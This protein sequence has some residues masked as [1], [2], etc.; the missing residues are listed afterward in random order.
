[1]APAYSTENATMVHASPQFLEFVKLRPEFLAIFTHVTP[2]QD[3]LRQA[4]GMTIHE[5]SRLRMTCQ[6]V[7]KSWKPFPHDAT[8]PDNLSEPYFSGLKP[9]QCDEPGC[10]NT[11]DKV[12]IRPCYGRKHP[13]AGIYCGCNKN[14]CIRCAQR[15]QKAFDHHNQTETELHCCLPCG[16]MVVGA[17]S[18]GEADLCNA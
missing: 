8:K 15:A 6:T 18:G 11:S 3:G 10:L 2:F 5:Y 1:M 13:M 9:V 4:G 7:A 12:A 16:E 17:S 14:V